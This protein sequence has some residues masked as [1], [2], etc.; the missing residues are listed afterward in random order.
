[1]S[2]V[3]VV[4][5]VP[6]LQVGAIG[7][8]D[9]VA[10][11]SS[12]CPATAFCVRCRKH[13]L[14]MSLN[15]ALRISKLFESISQNLSVQSNVWTSRVGLVTTLG[16]V[17]C[18][19]CW[20]MLCEIVLQVVNSSNHARRVCLAC[21]ANVQKFEAASFMFLCSSSQIEFPG[22]IS[23]VQEQINKR[24]KTASFR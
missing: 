23:Q 1:M 9:I 10:Q 7:T 13:G 17:A 16:L 15:P 11:A 14:N 24:K 18:W 5:R 12:S 20:R 4:L 8:E 3:T 19:P 22:M 2:V 6:F 21:R